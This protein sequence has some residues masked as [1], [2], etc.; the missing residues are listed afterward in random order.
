[1]SCILQDGFIDN[2]K[3]DY[4]FKD[5]TLEE[6]SLEE[7]VEEEIVN[8]VENETVDALYARL[9]EYKPLDLEEVW[10]YESIREEGKENEDYK[11]PE[12][13]DAEEVEE[14]IVEVQIAQVTGDFQS[15]S[16]EDRRRLANTALYDP[17][18]VRIKHSLN[19]MTDEIDFSRVY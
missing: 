1:M 5:L 14:A 8:V 3:S 9:N 12:V 7:Q 10:D 15:I 19:K 13:M 2:E 18:G 6:L 17:I 11:S 16:Y 4:H